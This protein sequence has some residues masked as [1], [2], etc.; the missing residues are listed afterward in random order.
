[1]ILRDVCVMAALGLCVGLPP[2]LMLS[3]LVRAFLYDVRPND[4]VTLA[5]AAVVIVIAAI[6]AGAG[7]A[8][9]A[10]RINPMTALRS[11]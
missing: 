2:A 6:A 1:M 11:E 5:G 9:R 7:P 10:A 8:F 4:P 3:G